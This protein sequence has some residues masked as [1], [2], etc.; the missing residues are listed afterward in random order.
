MVV[1]DLFSK[2]RAQELKTEPDV[3]QYG[4]C[5]DRLRG[6]IVH[7]L[8]D[9][10]GNPQVYKDEE[11]Q[12]AAKKIC[13]ILKREYGEFKLVEQ[14]HL[15]NS[16]LEELSNFIINEPKFEKVLD[17][18]EVS[19]R[20][21]DVITR[22]SY[23]EYNNMQQ[24]PDSAIKELN[25]RFLENNFGYQYENGSI[26]KIDTKLGHKE[27]I[28]PALSLLQDPIYK[29]T[30]KEYM[31]AHEDYKKGEYS[32]CIHKC[33]KSIETTMKIIC[34]K[35]GWAYSEND[36]AKKLIATI[37]TNNLIPQY[38]QTHF[39]SFQQMLESGVPTIRNKEGGHGIGTK[40]VQAYQHLASFQLH[41][42]ASLITL[43]IDSEKNL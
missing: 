18:V 38:L 10:I 27:I 30:N 20:W 33:A 5:P 31:E 39:T 32:D 37:L 3:F 13:N 35:R 29:N 16:N 15:R 4:V 6:Q 19:F 43:L 12:A 23:N 28:K 24:S 9:S 22:D 11:R 34:K 17:A 2:R 8:Q 25:A 26:I 21:I 41:Q 40:A 1:F 36:S 7:I 42:T 14:R